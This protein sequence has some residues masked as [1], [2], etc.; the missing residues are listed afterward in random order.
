MTDNGTPVLFDAKTFSITVSDACAFDSNLT[1]WTVFESGGTTSGKGNVRSESCQAVIREG[2]S[3][4]VGLE[5]SF[6]VPAQSSAISLTFANPSFDIASQG[7]VRD[8]FELALLD[9]EGNSLVATYAT[10]RD[11]FYNFTEGLSAQSASGIVVSGDTVTVGLGGLPI[12][13]TGKL[14]LRLVNNDSDKLSQ[15][16]IKSFELAPSQVMAALQTAIWQKTDLQ[17]GFSQSMEIFKI[18]HRVN[19][20]KLAWAAR[21]ARQQATFHQQ[22]HEEMGRLFYLATFPIRQNSK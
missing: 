1:G 20:I 13:T 21:S 12:G 7:F 3:F 8:A 9:T 14:V 19:R 15:V 6:T 22:L 5:R 2:D 16:T 4:V 10:G 11:S 18:R 17:T